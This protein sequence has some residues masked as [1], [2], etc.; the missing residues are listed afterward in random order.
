[1]TIREYVIRRNN[2]NI[3]IYFIILYNIDYIGTLQCAKI[4]VGYM[5]LLLMSSQYV[6]GT[7]LL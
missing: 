1:M 2:I 7:V 4:R 3:I 6:L 5:V